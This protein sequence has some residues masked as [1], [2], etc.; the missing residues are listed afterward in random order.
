VLAL[1][2]LVKHVPRSPRRVTHDILK[3]KA[4]PT[5]R[6]HEIT[7]I[8]SATFIFVLLGF[9]ILLRKVLCTRYSS[10]GI[11]IEVVFPA[12][13]RGGTKNVEVRNRKGGGAD[14]RAAPPAP[15]W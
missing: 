14:A 3:S 13:S 6:R 15:P 5:T 4:D 12:P 10:Y 11:F 9:T 7:L 2:S 1:R 8:A